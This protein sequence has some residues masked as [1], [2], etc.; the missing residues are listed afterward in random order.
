[1]TDFLARARASLALR[2]TE[3]NSDE[4]RSN[5]GNDEDGEIDEEQEIAN[6]LKF[7]EVTEDQRNSKYG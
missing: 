4:E 6:L 3:S 5:I 1:M 7:T 2:D